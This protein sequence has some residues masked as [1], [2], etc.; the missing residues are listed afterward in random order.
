MC[1]FSIGQQVVSNT[2][3]QGLQQD[4]VY[5]VY[6]IHTD[7]APW[8]TFTEYVVTDGAGNSLTV[9]N[10]HLLLDAYVSEDELASMDEESLSADARAALRIATLASPDR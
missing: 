7:V 1:Q 6:S 5:T 2:N 8:G 10:G 4:A 9:V 3:A